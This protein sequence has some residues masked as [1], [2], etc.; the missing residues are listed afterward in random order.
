M[1]RTIKGAEILLKS[2]LEHDVSTI[3]GY[4]GSCVMSILDYLY[5]N[6][7]TIKHILVRHERGAVYAAQGYA[8]VA[9]EVGVALVTSGP[10]ATNTV[11]GIADAMTNSIPLVVITGQVNSQMLGTD[12]FQEVDI[13]SIAHSIT[14]WVYQVRSASEIASAIGHAFYIAST[15]RPGPVLLDITKDAQVSEAVYIPQKINFIRSYTSFE[16]YDNKTINPNIVNNPEDNQV[17]KIVRVLQDVEKEII[18]ILDIENNCELELKNDKHIQL[19]NSGS[20]GFGLPT[21]IGAKYADP[22]KPVCL[23]VGSNW[24]QQSIQELGVVLQSNIDIKI[25]L[26][27][28]ETDRMN[29]DFLQVATAY[30][31]ENRKILSRL[32]IKEDI[33]QVLNSKGSY[34]LEVNPKIHYS[35]MP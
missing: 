35:K 20:K 27:N 6:E 28:D 18:V 30:N 16:I 9:Q 23:I 17:N 32:T 31:I 21:A 34:I 2:L 26:L 13:I 24:F 15:G 12:A 5:N 1:N 3:F 22:K 14:K 4:P 25:I 7:S 11:S 33:E 8:Q 19:L 29:P 10:G